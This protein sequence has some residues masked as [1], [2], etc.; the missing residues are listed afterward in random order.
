MTQK[1]RIEGGQ[2]DRDANLKF[3]FDGQTYHGHAGDT[4]ASA[5]LANGVRLMGRSFK[6][7]RPRGPLTAGSEEPN[8]LVQL[9]SGARQEP[10]TRAT[11]A[12]LFDGL[13]A[14]S[15][16]RLGSLSF[17]LLAI[18]DR[19]SNF[20]TAGFYY[21]TFMWPKAFWEK[22]YEPIIRRAAGLGSLSFQDDPDAYDKGFLHCDLLII[23]AGPAGLMAALTAARSGAD[24]ILA[25]EDFRMGGRLNSETFGIGDDAGADWAAQ[26]VAEL[27]AMPNVRLMARTT[28]I[29]AFDHGT[30]GA[31][32]RVSDHI[33][34]PMDGKPRQILWRIYTQK[35]VL[36]AG[37][38]ERPIAFNNNDRPGIM[39]ASALRSYANRF[40]VAVG[41]RTG[42]FTNNDD[43]HRTAADLYAKG[44]KVTVIDPRPDAP[45][46][47][48]Y[49]V[50]AGAQVT[51]T[52]GRLGLTFVQVRLSDGTDRTIECKALGVSGGWNPNVHMTC[53]QQ[54]RP[55]WNDALAAFVP[56]ALPVGM[57][58]AGA[59]KGDLSTAGALVGGAT[60]ARAALDLK[61]RMPKLPQAEDAPVTVTPFWYVEGASRA[62]LDQQNDVTV[63]DVK[64]SHQEG[65]KS[66]EHLKRYTTLGMATDQGKTAN[67]GGLAI[68]AE[69]AGK[70][71]PEVGTTMFRPPYTPVA[72]GAL[73]GR[74]RG[75]DF[76]PKRLTPT[77]AWAEEQGAV[78][79]EVGNW[80]RA[81]WFPHAG[82]TTWRESV[83]REVLATRG[84]VGVCDVTT[85]GK[86][87]VQGADAA[88]FLNMIYCNGFAKLPVGKVRYGLMLREDG[89]AMD[90]GTA[91]RM[92]EDH[93]VVTTTTAN[94]LPVYRHMEFVSQCLVPDMDVQLISTTE[95]W[96]QYAVAGPNARRVLEKIVDQDISND[97]FPFMACGDVTVCGGL[98]A[99]LFRI[100]FSGELAYELAVPTAY[101]DAL[102]RRIM[103]AGAEFDI[104][105]Y[106]TEALGV[107]RM[108]KGHAAGNELNGTTTAANL[109]MG[110]MVSTKKDSIGAVLSRREGLNQS[111]DLRA[112]GIKPVDPADKVPA[113]AHLMAA[114]GPV[115]AAHD[116]GYVT[117]ACYSPNLGH[118]IALAYLKDGSNRIGETMRLV[119]PLTGVD[120][121]VEI[122]SAH[123]IDPEGERLRA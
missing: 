106:G 9:R 55:A 116:Q 81:Q 100:S 39:T 62:W 102:I 86:V 32:E 14:T 108:E 11:T 118:H 112:V 16:N 65:F 58:V 103:E 76:H 78:F 80:M 30:Y 96:A 89:I 85:L 35:T 107:M 27:T 56:D 40:G 67:M 53:H 28:I 29:G 44:V 43:G 41:H 121:A 71:I 46:S 48:D 98:R 57:I 21:K 109:G 92:A 37:A 54:G 66:V 8:A 2:I 122:C 72:I 17:D 47:M 68:M 26:T 64:L 42:I 6:Y 19:V 50:L 95:A 18:N 117:S 10:N 13:T 5:L 84:S 15:Q 49:E 74:H 4:L 119:S 87:D 22:V 93:F 52:M 91:A 77:H 90:D 59:A 110:R 24:V 38:I 99:R 83:D 23:G 33:A 75:Q 25:D 34:T 7:H 114:E 82:E 31:V 63:K 104:T 111:D 36:A 94:A 1:N 88:A 113:G 60:A 73:G 70:T 51:D 61:G 120:V 69:L 20:L 3:T 12:E 115:D 79:V 105:P 97:A 123:F 101:G 45:R